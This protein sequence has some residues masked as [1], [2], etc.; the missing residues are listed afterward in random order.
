VPRCR[1]ALSGQHDRNVAD[2]VWS[3]TARPMKHLSRAVRAAAW[4]SSLRI[5]STSAIV[6]WTRMQPNR[7]FLGLS[8][9]TPSPRALRREIGS[10]A[11]FR[12]LA[13]VIL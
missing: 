2:C 9:M 13:N 7:A 5:G 11:A 4:C 1:S 6:G 3:C 8:L 10:T 12:T